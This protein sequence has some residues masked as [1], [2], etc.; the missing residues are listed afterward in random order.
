[1]GP[2]DRAGHSTLVLSENCRGQLLPPMPTPCRAQPAPAS[3]CRLDAQ[4]SPHSALALDGLCLPGLLR[5]GLGS[6]AFRVVPEP[7][8][9]RGWGWCRSPTGQS[10]C[11]ITAEPSQP[12][13]LIRGRSPEL[14][15]WRVW[16]GSGALQPAPAPAP[17]LAGC[18]GMELKCGCEAALWAPGGEAALMLALAAHARLLPVQGFTVPHGCP[19][20]SAPTLASGLL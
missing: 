10:G 20:V 19:C 15:T 3:P 7:W 11:S 1:M 9:G 17:G 5:R 6:W 4:D 13:G 2:E 12:P 16:V 8:A 14:Q 18:V